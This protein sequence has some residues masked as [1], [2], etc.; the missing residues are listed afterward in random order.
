MFIQRMLR[1]YVM[2]APEPRE[3]QEAQ[4][5]ACNED[6]RWFWRFTNRFEVANDESVLGSQTSGANGCIPH[7]QCIDFKS[8]LG[9]LEGAV[10]RS[11]EREG[12]TSG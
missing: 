3:G 1:S 10:L 7:T 8:D 11:I 4:S 9:R 2:P 12:E 5:A 6:S